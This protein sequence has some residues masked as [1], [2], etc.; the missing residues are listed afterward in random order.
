GAECTRLDCTYLRRTATACQPAHISFIRYKISVDMP[1]GRPDNHRY[2]TV[3]GCSHK[4]DDSSM[5]QSP[6]APAFLPL[7][8][9]IKT[10]LEMSLEVREWRPGEAIPSE[11]ELASRFG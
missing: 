1:G 11:I 4:R 8:V 5:S 10:L 7:Y 3:F 6:S 9:Q 2:R